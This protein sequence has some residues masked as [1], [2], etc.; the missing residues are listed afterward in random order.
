MSTRRP[1]PPAGSSGYAPTGPR[2]LIVVAQ[3]AAELRASGT[4]VASAAG[5]EVS[6]IA[7]ILANAGASM[8]P[9]FGASEERVRSAT[10]GAMAA[11]AAATGTE[12]P[13]LATFYRV[14]APDAALDQLARELRAHD[15]V[16]TAYVKPPAEPAV[17]N[18]MA[19][20]A[21]D[22]PP[23]TADFTSRQGYLEAA[24]GG[25]DAR[26]AWTRTGGGG[27]GVRIID[28]EGAWR[29]SHE[30]LVQA[31]GGVVGGTPIADIGWRNHG[32]AVLGEFSGDRNAFGV[33]GICPDAVVS[34]VSFNPNGSAAAIRA[35]A[36]RLG[37]GDV[38]LIELHRPGP[39]FNFQGRNDQLGYIAVEWWPDDFAAI[40]YAVGRG[41]T[42]VEA[43]GN[44]A[45]NLADA[46]YDVNPGNTFPSTWRNP[47]RRSPADSGA[48]LVGA[49]APPPGTHGRDHG[50]DRSRLDFSNFG[51][52]V[53][54][55]GWGREV[56][57]CGY[58][59]LQGGTNEDI[60]YTDQFSGT[61]SASPIVVGVVGA[62]QGALRAAGRPVLTPAQ[63]R[64]ALRSTGSPQQDAAG[65]PATQR[66]GNRPNLRQLIDQLIPAPSQMVPLYRYWNGAAGDHFYT[67]SWSELGTGRNGWA[68][69]GVQC[70]V[71]STAR[72]G[73]AALHRYWNAGATDHFY[74]TNWAELGSGRYGWAYEGVQCYVPVQQQAGTVPLYRYWN[75]GIGDHFYTTSWAEL[76]GGRYGW[77]YEG[78]QCYVNPQAVPASPSAG[79]PATAAEP[80]EEVRAGE[81]VAG[82][83]AVPPSFA[84]G[85][86]PAEEPEPV[87]PAAGDGG[88]TGNGFDGSFSVPE[89]FRVAGSNGEHGASGGRPRQVT[90][91]FSDQ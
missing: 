73:T 17:L 13:E 12:A 79:A 34:A 9:L 22:A 51:P 33:T 28:V 31:Q 82:G 83:R 40:Q 71:S 67:T 46:I 3:P 52:N 16:E 86:A 61:S 37:P 76:G 84:M 25:V 43:A 35:A 87:G 77:V 80:A 65:R 64:A 74:T 38:L 68:Y 15:A 59:D 8:H 57:T 75:A 66:I 81:A 45:E 32:T 20:A 70:Y 56:T 60:W 44:G 27:A 72:P 78:V 49:G 90:V 55:Q 58:G 88:H 54:A 29:F 47:F 18:D 42:V 53:D 50:P 1:R 48:V 62:L 21:A 69:E 39:R 14:D 7:G 23:V 91:T 89:W 10:A 30:D 2:E 26:Y 41:V 11:A 19:P 36:D 4:A 85:A 6:G 5:A 63:V 24:P